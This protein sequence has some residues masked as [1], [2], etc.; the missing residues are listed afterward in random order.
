MVSEVFDQVWP[1]I[2]FNK[3]TGCASEVELDR[4][5][6]FQLV[7]AQRG[8]TLFTAANK[9]QNNGVFKNTETNMCCQSNYE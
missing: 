8:V 4:Y 3:A 5:W 9:G 2:N 1:N 6:R 7:R